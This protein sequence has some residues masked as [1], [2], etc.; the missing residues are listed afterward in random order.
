MTKAVD[1]LMAHYP[2]NLGRMQ[3]DIRVALQ[4]AEMG[5]KDAA[6][7]RI[8][9]LGPKV[10]AHVREMMAGLEALITTFKCREQQFVHAASRRSG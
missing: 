8:S 2:V 4:L 3:A 9:I 10:S 1:D 6:L 7:Y 5:E